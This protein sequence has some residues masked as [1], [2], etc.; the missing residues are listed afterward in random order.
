MMRLGRF[1]RKRKINGEK[2]YQF[3]NQ[4]LMIIIEKFHKAG[5]FYWP[6]KTQQLGR[7]G[8]GFNK[9]VFRKLEDLLIYIREENEF[10][11]LAKKPED[12]GKDREKQTT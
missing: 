11:K 9:K 4:K 1:V 3:E 6:E 5:K 12:V 8:I 2:I 10:F 7:E